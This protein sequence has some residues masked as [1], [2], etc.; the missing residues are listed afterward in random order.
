MQYEI[1]HAIGKDTMFTET[2]NQIR[3]LVGVVEAD[4]LEHAYT[5]SQNFDKPW[6]SFLPCR[7]TSVGDV[8][9]DDKG[10]Y[11]VC[12][13]GFKAISPFWSSEEEMT[14]AD[15]WNGEPYLQQ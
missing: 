15:Y 7:S 5:L 9:K 1:F 13:V 4:S 2:E 6:S 8:I 14:E 12:N 10:C 11:M 3:I